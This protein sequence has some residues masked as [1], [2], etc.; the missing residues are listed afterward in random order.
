MPVNTVGGLTRDGRW[1]A[2]FETLTNGPSLG[3]LP[4]RAST[5][6]RRRLRSLLYLDTPLQPKTT[7][8][9]PPPHKAGN[10]LHFE[11][12]VPATNMKVRYPVDLILDGASRYCGFIDF[13]AQ[14]SWMA[15]Q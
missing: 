4:G 13:E 12:F 10:G 2:N 6:A 1:L 5:G 11:F 7:K 3:T 14:A 9:A 15:T 8:V